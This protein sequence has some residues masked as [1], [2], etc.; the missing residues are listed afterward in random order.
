MDKSASLD[1]VGTDETQFIAVDYHC[2]KVVAERTIGWVLL[3]IATPIILLITCV[4]RLTSSGKGI[5]KQV[6]VGKNGHEFLI[7]KIRSMYEDAEACGNPQWST[8][9]DSRI[10]PVGRVLR[11]LHLDELPQLINV[12]RGE[13]SLVGPRPERPEFVE[14]L[15]ITVPHYLDRLQVLPGVTGLAQINLPADESLESVRKKVILDCEYIRTASLILDLRI[16]F[17]TFFRMTGLRHGVAPKLF[18]VERDPD[19]LAS[20]FAARSG[21]INFTSSLDD[22]QISIPS[23]LEPASV[24]GN[25]ENSAAQEQPQVAYATQTSPTSSLPDVCTPTED[26]SRRHPR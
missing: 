8:R 18:G 12:A 7:Y 1:R 3:I 22:S 16:F 19:E 13:M 5:Y 26:V 11:F 17:C 15:A 2:S 6:R 20:S 10:T 23:M 21:N 4:V 9:G 24:N 25:G 14:Q